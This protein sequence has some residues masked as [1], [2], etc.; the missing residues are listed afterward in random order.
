MFFYKLFYF[1][2]GYVIIEI[3]GFFIERF[4]NILVHRGIKLRRVI[5]TD[6]TKAEIIVSNHDFKKL[7]GPVKKANVKVRILKKCGLKALFKRYRKRYAFFIGAFLFVL[8][9]V[10]SS[11]FIWSVEIEG[12]NHLEKSMILEVLKQEGVYT[13]AKKSRMSKPREIKDSLMRNF[14]SI[15]WAWAYLEGTNVRIL[16]N[17]GKLPP[18]ITD[19][20]VPCDIVAIRDGLIEE[21]TVKQGK[22]ELSKD[23]PVV[24]GDVLIAGTIPKKDDTVYRTVHA[25]GEVLAR[26]YHEKT[27]TY[28]LHNEH[29]IPTGNK[30]SGYTLEL[31]SKTFNFGLKKNKFKD[32]DVFEKSFKAKFGKKYYLGL[33]VTRTEYREVEIVKEPIPYE[34]AVSFAEYDLE[35]KIAEELLLGAV[36]R[37]RETTVKDIDDETIEVTLLMEFTENIGAKKIIYTDEVKNYDA[38]NNG[39]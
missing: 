12:T 22:T 9:F 4:I 20:N 15:T 18:E 27:G 32:Y 26:T 6:K 13:G 35:Q 28:K 14:R 5:K 33:G 11:Q 1:L 2:K 23:T 10:V 36:L 38:E 37:D 29:R 30:I 7:R 3:E 34:S 21:V 25:E 31:F 24:K 8:F 39:N 16:I 19:K 17:E